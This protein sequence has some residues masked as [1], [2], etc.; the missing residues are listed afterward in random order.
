LD[1]DRGSLHGPEGESKLRRQAFKLLRV[2]VE[3]APNILSHDQ[4][5]DLVWGKEHLSAS[6]LKQAISEVR[7]ALGD[8]PAKPTFVE[9]IHRRGYRFIAPVDI[10]NPTGSSSLSD[11]GRSHHTSGPPTRSRTPLGIGLLVLLVVGGVVALWMQDR[12]AR[13]APAR[14]SIAILGLAVIPD[15]TDRAWTSEYLGRTLANELLGDLDAAEDWLTQS[16]DLARKTG[17]RFLEGRCIRTRADFN[18]KRGKVDRARPDYEAALGI[19]REISNP[20]EEGRTLE[21]MAA[22]E[23][24]DG[25]IGE[26]IPLLKSAV[27]RYRAGSHLADQASALRSLAEAHSELGQIDTARN[28]LEEA[29]RQAQ[30]L[31][32]TKLIEAI[33]ADLESLPTMDQ[34]PGVDN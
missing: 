15:D 33:E 23:T 27:E 9:T 22:M 29:M 11:Q 28:N 14:N 21:A 16:G 10:V 7:Q 20:L 32:N 6:S 26:A 31:K 34:I 30:S 2:L 25:K 1:L 12:Q 4:L 3:E 5:L 17:D 18:R 19:F 13:A 8:D 24:E